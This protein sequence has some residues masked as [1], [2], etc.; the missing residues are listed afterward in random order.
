M[1]SILDT[2]AN[3]TNGK[4]YKTYKYCYDKPGVPSLE[5]DDH[6]EISWQRNGETILHK[7]SVNLV[8]KAQQIVYHEPIFRYFLDGS[9]RV[10]KVDDMAYRNRVFPIVAGQIGVG[11]CERLNKEM[12]PFEYD[13]GLA[14][15]LP[16][17]AN[18]LDWDEKGHFFSN[19]LSQINQVNTLS[20]REIQFT[21]ILP[22]K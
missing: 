14:I 19:L 10:F 8:K 11:C 20:K 18:Q 2:I 7:K 1:S 3:A 22:Y 21:N 9:R 17:I 16:E 13:Y 4:S 15:S 12:K 5:Y 6:K